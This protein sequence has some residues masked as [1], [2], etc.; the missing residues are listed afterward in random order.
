[1]FQ[2]DY[3]LYGTKKVGVID[4]VYFCEQGVGIMTRRG[5]TMREHITKVSPLGERSVLGRR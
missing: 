3:G 2:P 4:V 1:M 5:P